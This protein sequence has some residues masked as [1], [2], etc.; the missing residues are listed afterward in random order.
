MKRI[1]KLDL[2]LLSIA[3]LLAMIGM[4]HWASINALEADLA[5]FAAGRI[6]KIQGPIHIDRRFGA[7]SAD[8]NRVLL[9]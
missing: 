8:V 5:R 6:D 3:I 4:F 2:G 1:K 9:G 7:I